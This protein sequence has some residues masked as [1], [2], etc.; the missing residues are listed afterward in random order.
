M[1]PKL[2]YLYVLYNLISGVF[3]NYQEL[4]SNILNISGLLSIGIGS[5]AGIN[6]TNIK[7]LIA[8]SGISHTG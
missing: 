4:I 8:Y 7:R 5:I 1:F 6:Q 3:Y 2:V